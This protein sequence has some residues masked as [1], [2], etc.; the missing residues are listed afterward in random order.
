MSIG[1]PVQSIDFE[2]VISLNVK[3]LENDTR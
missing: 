2:V 1:T 3:W